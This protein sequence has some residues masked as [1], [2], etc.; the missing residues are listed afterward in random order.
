MKESIG[1][2]ITKVAAVVAITSTACLDSVWAGFYVIAGVAM[3]IAIAGMVKYYTY[4]E[5]EE[6]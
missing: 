1:K 4:T 5:K 2:M 6:K 3:V